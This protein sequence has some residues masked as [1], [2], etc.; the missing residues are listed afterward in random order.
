MGPMWK[1]LPMVGFLLLS[2]CGEVEPSNEASVDRAVEVARAILAEGDSIDSFDRISAAGVLLS[3]GVEDTH[4]AISEALTSGASLAQQAAV[5]A[6]LGVPGT[7]TMERITT[8]ADESDRNFTQVLQALRWAPR[9]DGRALVLRGLAN[10]QPGSQV[11]AF[12]I[13]AELVGDPELVAAIED[14]IRRSDE[15]HVRGYGVY[16]ASAL[17]SPQAFRLIVPMMRGQVFEREMAAACLGHV[18]TEASREALESLLEDRQPG[19]RLAAWASLSHFGNEHA[20]DEIYAALEHPELGATAAGSVRRASSE[21]IEA[22]VLRAGD[23]SGIEVFAAGRVLEAIGW[24]PDAEASY[25]LESALATESELLKLQ[26]LWAVGWRGKSEERSLAEA[27]LGDP[28][29]AVRTM[30][31]WAVVSNHN[32]GRKLG[33]SKAQ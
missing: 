31:A 23:W 26:S 30:A 16:A 14:A 29:S 17:G 1:R 24:R 19:V 12:D 22:I 33:Q 6:L 5:G 21:A 27:H 20:V 13:A 2:A 10:S 11:A 25:G 28:S 15:D 9:A 18:K 32:G 4:E 7:T 3:A 8:F